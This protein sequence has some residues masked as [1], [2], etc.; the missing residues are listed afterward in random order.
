MDSGNSQPPC[1][2]KEDVRKPKLIR[3][4]AAASLFAVLA[5][6]P[7][8]A[9]DAALLNLV[10]PDAK[11]VAGADVDRVK[12]SPFGQHLLKQMQD[13]DRDF[14]DFFALTGFDPRTDLRE[15]LAATDSTDKS[16][17]G[18]VAARGTFDETKLSAAAS[19]KGGLITTYQGI[20][21]LTP[22]AGTGHGDGAVAFL[23]NGFVLAGPSASVKAAIDRQSA[24]LK[25]SPDLAARIQSASSSYDAWVVTTASPANL[26]RIPAPAALDGAMQGNLVQAIDYIS[27]GVRFGANV[28]LA[29]EAVTRTEKDAGALADVVRFLASMA[30]SNRDPKSSFAQMVDSLQLTAE[31][32]TVRFTISAPEQEIEKLIAPRRNRS[33]KKIVYRR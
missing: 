15:I 8:L 14:Q 10:M 30:A 29:G 32:R 26:G 12:N 22:P 9:V 11:V 31:G 28:E 4:L 24:G 21:L 17:R 16:S 6:T 20:K 18:I 13:D 5:A 7:A 1:A 27:G 23:G 25:I 33:T 2:V 3:K 19:V